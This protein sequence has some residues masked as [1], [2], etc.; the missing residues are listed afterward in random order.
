MRKGQRRKFLLAS[1]AL[2][3]VPLAKAQQSTRQ[4]RIGVLQIGN[5]ATS[6]PVEEGIL[7]GLRDRGYVVGQ[8][9]VA[10]FRYSDGDRTRLQ[11]LADEL[12]ALKPDVLVG[13]EI[14]SSVLKA[15]TSTIPIVLLISADPVAAGLVK[16]LARPGTNVTGMAAQ[17]H[18][19]VAKQV[20]LLTELVPKMSRIA[21][22]TGPFNPPEDSPQFGRPDP[23]EVAAQT[24]AR[25]KG[26]TLVVVRV[27]DSES[28]QIAFATLKKERPDGILIA[29]HAVILRLWREVIDGARL[30]R[31]PAVSGLGFHVEAGGLLSYGLNLVEIYRYAA[32]FVDLIAKGAKPADLPVE[33]VSQFQLFVNQKTARELGLKIPP[34]ILLRADRVIE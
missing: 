24:S 13:T 17:L 18:T 29:T 1:G 27:H 9:L 20:E 11:A 3:V 26:L 5:A 21:L 16:S 14:T 15:K 22:M 25:A 4:I 23:W 12:I 10:D 28:L 19:V 2:L 34:S 30:L 31:I 33:Q 32:K 7:A 8:N 6:K